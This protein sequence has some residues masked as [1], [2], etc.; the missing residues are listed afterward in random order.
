MK[1]YSLVQIL[2]GSISVGEN[3]IPINKIEIPIIQRDYA[4]GRKSEQDVRD[5]FLSKIFNSLKNGEKME[6]DFIYGSFEKGKFIPLDGQQRL[7][8][9]YL[10]HWYIISREFGVDERKKLLTPLEKFTYATRVSSRDFC[11]ALIDDCDINMDDQ[12]IISQKIKDRNWFTGAFKKDPTITSMLTMLDDIQKYYLSHSEL[13]EQLKNLQF[14][15][16]PL[17]EFKLSEELY[18]R[19]NARGKPLSSFEIFK[20]DL[21][22]YITTNENLRIPVEYRG[23]RMTF[24]ESLLHKIDNEWLDFFWF[25]RKEFYTGKFDEKTKNDNAY[26]AKETD[27]F[28]LF[29]YRFFFN[30]IASQDKP[31]KIS[32]KD[33]QYQFFFGETPYR[34]FT[35]FKEISDE[36]PSSIFEKFEKVLDTFYSHKD[37]IRI[38]PSWG[39]E[40]DILSLETQPR[41]CVF[42]AIIAF[43]VR[44]EFDSQAFDKWMRV[45][46]N[47]VENTD[48]SDLSSMLGV[49]KLINEIS[50]NSHSIYEFLAD[51][52]SVIKSQSSQSAIAEER[53]KC[54]FIMGDSH[55]EEVFILAEKHP[56]FKGSIDFL[57]SDGMSIEEFRHRF[58]MATRVFDAKGVNEKYRS[59]GHVFLRSIIA[60]Y[61]KDNFTDKNYTDIDEKEHYLKK[62]LKNDTIKNA[63]RG[64]FDSKDESEL[65]KTLNIH[66]DNISSISAHKQLCEDKELQNW[67]QNN[68]AIRVSYHYD[69]I[70]ASRPRSWY[71]WAMLSSN[72]NFIIKELIDKYGFSSDSPCIPGTHLYQGKTIIL[73][74]NANNMSIR[75]RFPEDSEYMQIFI[76]KNSDSGELISSLENRFSYNDENFNIENFC[77]EM[78]STLKNA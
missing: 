36:S 11:K 42:A 5:K 71:D 51:K 65:I 24:R 70:Y 68:S 2:T 31:V 33:E 12:A 44:G 43:I 58:Y 16:L 49:I 54:T 26:N 35:P 61:N 19:M 72:R 53:R 45:V 62:H 4:Q 10:L 25:L 28:L 9:L 59:D 41:R 34:S 32:E 52:N 74:K 13:Y 22:K 64:W 17:N 18:V 20:A 40:I 39:E 76:S 21:D 38:S 7:T 48:I 55:W 14:L 60:T 46:W 56:F 37:D 75:V 77:A 8:T 1:K 78:E 47:I 63:I 30:L 29:F 50:E 69:Q 6:L 66:I 67:M 23:S 57:I 3:S 73:E 15:I 27:P